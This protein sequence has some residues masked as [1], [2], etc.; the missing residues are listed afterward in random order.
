[1]IE[2][3]AEISYIVSH[4]FRGCSWFL[5]HELPWS[6]SPRI[7]PWGLAFA[8]YSSSYLSLHDSLYCSYL[9]GVA[10]FRGLRGNRIERNLSIQFLPINDFV[11]IGFL[12]F[13]GIYKIC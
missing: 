11:S 8:R 2:F 7:D 13:M 1:M 5:L 12:E 9:G 6:L 3:T 4:L 10:S